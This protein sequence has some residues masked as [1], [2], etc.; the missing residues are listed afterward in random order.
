M[1]TNKMFNIEENIHVYR[2]VCIMKALK[3]PS[4]R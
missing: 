3:S 1:F 2:N 4:F